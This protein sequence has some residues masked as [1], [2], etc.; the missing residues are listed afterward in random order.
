M[1]TIYFITITN[2]LTAE[3]KRREHKFMC[4]KTR[5]KIFW[6]GRCIVISCRAETI[7][8]LCVF[9]IF[10][11]IGFSL[12]CYSF[13]VTVIDAHKGAQNILQISDCFAHNWPNVSMWFH[14][15]PWF[16]RLSPFYVSR[17]WMSDSTDL[18][19]VGNESWLAMNDERWNE[20]ARTHNSFKVMTRCACAGGVY[21]NAE[22]TTH[23][24][25]QN[26]TDVMAN[27]QQTAVVTKHAAKEYVAQSKEKQKNRIHKPLI[28]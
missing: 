24:P 11:C 17:V 15:V 7:I 10:I 4:K 19:R 28:E 1:P 3:C 18:K 27:Q 5:K 26:N 23:L 6:A 16:I 22:C 14:R 12:V 21:A 9:L 8:L 2:N 20:T 13:V 25:I